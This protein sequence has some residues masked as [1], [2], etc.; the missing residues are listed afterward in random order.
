[1]SSIL[2]QNIK[3]L[4]Q[5]D[6]G[7]RTVIKGKAMSEIP[8]IND[9][10]LLIDKNKIAGFGAM[11]TGVDSADVI[12]DASGKM[13]LPAWCDSHTHLVYA[14]NR[15][16]EF[17]MRLKG[18][19]YEEIAASGGGILNSAKKLQ[20]M[21]ESELFDRALE[22]L[23]ELKNSGTG[24]IEIKSGYGLTIDAELKMLRV[25]RKLKEQSNVFIKATFLGAHALPKEYINNR[26]G[27]IRLII[28]EML[29]R[30]AAEGLA[31]YC[32]VFCE[33]NYFT[34]DETDII[35][36]AAAKYKLKPKIH[37]NQ[38]SNSGGVQVGIKNN[39]LTVDHLEYLGD[40]EIQALKKS[41]TLPVALPSCSFFI[42]I[43]YTPGR[44][45]IDAGLPLVLAS[46]FN[47]GSSPSGNI[48]FVIAL[49]CIK[50]QLTPNEAINAVTLNGAA[51]MEAEKELGSIAIGKKANIII[52]KKINSLAEIPYSF[53]RNLI[54]QAIVSGEC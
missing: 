11:G 24:A 29:P 38:F 16:E 48:S 43:P 5:T 1:M 14:A 7:S 52:T 44:K 3:T 25:I 50:M 9:A 36:K 37:V 28:E 32:D 23:T 42:N 35:L 39:A 40:E 10:W 41:N 45:I 51:A 18:M 12:I 31:D 26:G 21:D 47:P 49:A 34:N 27:Y 8:H 53:G 46:D 6:T 13:V 20:Q 33:K 17:E 15:E 30:I 19:T 2:I 4:W 54:E 22:R